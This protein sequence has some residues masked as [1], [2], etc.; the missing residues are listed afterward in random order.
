MNKISCDTCLDLVPLVKDGVSSQDSKKL[1]EDHI[2][3]CEE[4][5]DIYHDFNPIEIEDFDIDYDKTL[6]KIKRKLYALA[7]LILIIGSVLGLSLNDSQGIFY[8]ILIMPLL[9]GVAYLVF[10]KK[11]YIVAIFIFIISFVHQGIHGYLEGYLTNMKDV[12]LASGQMSVI[13][14]MFFFVGIIILR[15]LTIAIYGGKENRNESNN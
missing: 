9:G 4:C 14:L 15:L 12:F 11:A 8:N 13:F 7:G 3:T 2:E 6:G 5:R 1:V 10:N